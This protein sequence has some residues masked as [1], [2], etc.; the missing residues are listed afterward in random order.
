[1]SAATAENLDDD[2]ITTIDIEDEEEQRRARGDFLPEPGDDTQQQAAPGGAGDAQPPKPDD[3]PM[4]PKSRLDDA[5]MRARMAE[6]ELARLAEQRA[7]AAAA[8]PEPP[9]EYDYEQRER[10]YLAALAEFDQERSLAIR[11]E[12]DQ[13]RLADLEQR[14]ADAVER[15]LEERM[16]QQRITDAADAIARELPFLAENNWQNDAVRDFNVFRAGY[17]QS[18]MEAVAAM[19]AAA[20]KIAKLYAS[21]PLSTGSPA[22]GGAGQAADPQADRNRQAAAR[23]ALASTRQ[24]PLPAAGVGNRAVPS[25]DVEHM[26]EDEFRAIP[27]A[28][29]RKLRGD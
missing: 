24:P 27:E 18:G 3:E 13:R 2:I 20:D 4:I 15:K 8:P 22:A 25:Y 14:A 10:D 29:K 26:S 21:A 12:I 1:M 28:E 7:A 19:R 17:Q 11:R 23:G 9:P 5:L 16:Q 6:A